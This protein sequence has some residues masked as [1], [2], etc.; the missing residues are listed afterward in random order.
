MTVH[1]DE[2]IMQVSQQPAEGQRMVLTP[3]QIKLVADKVYAM[4]LNELRIEAERSRPAVR[5]WKGRN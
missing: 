1:M 5:P 4:L 3:E 2:I